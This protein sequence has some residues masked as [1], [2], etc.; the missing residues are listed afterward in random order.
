MAGRMTSDD[1]AVE[2][3]SRTMRNPMVYALDSCAN[4][5][6]IGDIS[7]PCVQ[8]LTG[9][10][11]VTLTAAGPIP[12]RTADLDTPFGVREGL[13][14]ID[15]PP[16]APESVITAKGHRDRRSD[17]MSVSVLASILNPQS[18]CPSSVIDSDGMIS[19]PCVVRGGIPFIAFSQWW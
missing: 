2:F 7:H 15:C 17:I 10:S 12:F 8:R 13:V 1:D 11:S 16:V 14:I 18:F 19:I 3:F 4:R 9:G 6:C 5:F